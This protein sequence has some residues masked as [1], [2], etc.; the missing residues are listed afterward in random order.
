MELHS[1][2]VHML[3]FALALQSRATNGSQ[4]QSVL[5]ELVSAWRRG[6][7]DVEASLKAFL[8]SYFAHALFP[9]FLCVCV[10][11][12]FKALK[13]R[14]QSEQQSCTYPSLCNVICRAAFVRRNTTQTEARL[15]CVRC[16]RSQGRRRRHKCSGTWWSQNCPWTG[17]EKDASVCCR[18]V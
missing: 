16:V 8:P 15:T 13:Y 5:H 6:C 12:V 10:L 14:A 11:T 18:G 1:Q 4:R 2:S 9:L 17:A 7:F 3:T